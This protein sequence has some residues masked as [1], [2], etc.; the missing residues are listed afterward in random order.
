VLLVIVFAACATTVLVDCSSGCGS[1]EIAFYGGR[2]FRDLE[3]RRRKDRCKPHGG[4]EAVE[5]RGVDKSSNLRPKV[6]HGVKNETFASP[7][8][9]G[10]NL[11]APV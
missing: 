4:C 9:A 10:R 3:S 8:R 6:F 11:R 5:G 1:R 7:E 2:L